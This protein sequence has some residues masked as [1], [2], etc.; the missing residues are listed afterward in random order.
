MSKMVQSNIFL[1]NADTSIPVFWIVTSHDFK[2]Q[3]S[4]V[5]SRVQFPEVKALNSGRVLPDN[6]NSEFWEQSSD[7]SWGSANMQK[8]SNQL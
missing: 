5:F 4:V 7:F 1:R 8:F 2:I 6:Q 3:N